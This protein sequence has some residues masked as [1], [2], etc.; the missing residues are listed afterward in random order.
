MSVVRYDIP[1]IEDLEPSSYG[2]WVPYDEYED[3]EVQ[4]EE[5]QRNAISRKDLQGYVVAITNLSVKLTDLSSE[6]YNLSRRLEEKAN[7]S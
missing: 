2:A 5:L 6:L 4:L 7:E 1:Q 3:L